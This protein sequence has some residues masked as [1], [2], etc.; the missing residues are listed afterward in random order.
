MSLSDTW[1]L[2]PIGAYLCVVL[3][4]HPCWPSYSWRIF[5]FAAE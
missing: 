2:P 3:S 4:G 1:A 5:A